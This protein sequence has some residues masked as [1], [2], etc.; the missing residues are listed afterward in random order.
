MMNFM[1][2]LV[3]LRHGKSSWN[4]KNLFTGWVDVPL[5]RE[6]VEEALSAG[7]R[8]SKFRFDAIYTSTLVRAQT[9]AFLAMSRSSD[10]RDPIVIHEDKAWYEPHVEIPSIPVYCIEALNERFYGKLQGMDKDVARAAFG[11]EQVHIWRRSFDVPP[12]EGESL[13]LTCKRTLPF[14]ETEILPRIQKGETIF[15][16]A[17]GNSLRSIV[18]KIEQMDN[19][20]ILD[21]EI[22]TGNPLLY[23]WEKNQ[24]GLS[25][26]S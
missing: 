24:W 22:A 23:T 14:F 12:P 13:E 4:L 15:I 21:Y 9:T 11:K 20:Q 26:L 7:E 19:Q 18:K 16:V 5:C 10:E 25:A 1:G 8:L 6:G 2:Q 17:H 3:L